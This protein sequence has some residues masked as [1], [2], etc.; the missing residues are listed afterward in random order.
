MMHQ[1][2]EV[3]YADAFN[4]YEAGRFQEAV[5]AFRHLCFLHPFE[6]KFWFGLAASLQESRSYPEALEAWAVTA[7][8]NPKA[9]HPHFH[10]AECYFSLQNREEAL[11]ALDE[12]AMKVGND[13][14]LEEKIAFLRQQWRSEACLSP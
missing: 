1:E 6:A 5:E 2:A 11:T 3:L 4:Q 8:L 14:D 12:A 9:P 10:A 7:L 13:V